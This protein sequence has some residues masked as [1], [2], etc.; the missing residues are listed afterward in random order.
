M[1]EIRL[2]TASVLRAVRLD[3]KWTLGHMSGSVL[4]GTEETCGVMEV[5]YITTNW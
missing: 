1:L 5:F 3:E 2:V 4:K